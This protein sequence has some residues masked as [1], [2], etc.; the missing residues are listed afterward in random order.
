MKVEYGKL[1]GDVYIADEFTLHGMITGS[2]TVA[3][4]GRLVLHGMVCQDLI[5]ERE[6]STLSRLI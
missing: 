3:T 1:E 2:A 4:G 6:A 5:L